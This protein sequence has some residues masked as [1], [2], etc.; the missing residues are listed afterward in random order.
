MHEQLHGTLGTIEDRTVETGAQCLS[1][2]LVG[3]DGSIA[4]KA[5][6]CATASGEFGCVSQGKPR[7]NGEK[8][9]L[10]KHRTRVLL[11]V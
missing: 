3:V 8:E 2:R 4:L 6:R 11:M 10:S 1:D 7:E 5:Q 9:K